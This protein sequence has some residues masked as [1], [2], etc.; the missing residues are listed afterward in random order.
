MGVGVLVGFLGGVFV[1]AAGLG[2]LFWRLD[3]RNR[4]AWQAEVDAYEAEVADLR[5]DQTADRENNRRLR[6][7]LA[8]NTPDSLAITRQ[9]RDQAL[10]E[11]DQL[12]ADMRKA[13]SALI[14]RDSA[15][16]EARLAIHDIRVQLE[17]E[18]V[19]VAGRAAVLPMVGAASKAQASEELARGA[20]ET[21]DELYGGYAIGDATAS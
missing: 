21:D 17:R 4:L 3:K 14:D 12:T 15:L 10:D 2:S 6:R 1:S 11:L 19:E 8:I 7:E 16:R 13:T 9:E 5:R 20:A 18:R